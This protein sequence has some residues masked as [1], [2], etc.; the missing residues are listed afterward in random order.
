MN[1]NG[2]FNDLNLTKKDVPYILLLIFLTSIPITL[3]FTNPHILHG[4]DVSIY[5]FN[6]IKL[7]GVHTNFNIDPKYLFLTPILSFLT[8]ILIRLGVDYFISWVL[9]IGL[10]EL[11][12]TISFY[13]FLKNRFNCLLSLA[14]GIFLIV[15]SNSLYILLLTLTDIAAIG[16]TILTLTFF[17]AGVNKNPKFY[18][19][20]AITFI[21]SFFT[22]YA[23]GFILPLMIFYYLSRHDFFIGLDNF[24]SNRKEFKSRM[25]SYLKSSD[26]KFLIISLGLTLV[27]FYLF[28]RSLISLDS[29]LGFISQTQN[30]VT[31]F[32]TPQDIYY[33]TN[34]YYYITR[35]KDGLFNKTV[36]LFGIRF[37]YIVFS[38]LIIGF[39]LKFYNL[40][41]N[42]DFIKEI[43][44]N[45]YTFKTK[46]LN[47][48]LIISLFILCALMYLMRHSNTIYVMIFFFIAFT[49]CLSFINRLYINKENYS[50][51][52]LMIC[53]FCA[54]FLFFSLINIKVHRYIITTYPAF[55]YLFLL[56]VEEIFTDINYNFIPLKEKYL[57][58]AFR[59]EFD[60][61]MKSNIERALVLLF[62]LFLVVNSVNAMTNYEFSQR[63]Y[64]IQ[65]M[66]DFIIDYDPSYQSK[67][68]I[69]L[70]NYFRYFELDLDKQIDFINDWE[71]DN[72][73][74]YNA[75]YIILNDTISDPNY[76]SIHQVG[77]FTLY[78]HV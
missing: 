50:L 47:V 2:F 37:I 39:M 30:S 59:F 46:Y 32:N 26:F 15:T 1:I 73:T 13:V 56:S 8:S 41:K 74:T 76:N 33:S 68:F 11:V 7:S 42:I 75:T 62:I 24:I 4:Y 27:L 40:I 48:F 60:K 34:S 9:I 51:T 63:S 61:N 54:Y 64:D 67:D 35:F 45:R 69:T 77:I 14:G 78:E 16:L 43:Y 52:L 53:M 72:I 49:I 57:T 66:S 28:C 20:T 10:F 38:I 17:I 71:S 58:K 70:N 23:T 5:V 29:N 36:R 21:L 65:D 55:I 44:N 22:R 6:S 31:G 12:A 3:K 25:T 19:L 18:I